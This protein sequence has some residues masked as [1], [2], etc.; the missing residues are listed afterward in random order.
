MNLKQSILATLAF[1]DIFDHPLRLEEIQ[2]NL[3]HITEKKELIKQYLKESGKVD[4]YDGFYFLFNKK[5]LISKRFHRQKSIDKAWSKIEGVQR[6]IAWLP[7]IEHISV[8]N[9]LALN[10]YDK[11][12]DMDLFIITKDKRLFTARFL[13]TLVFH[14]FGLRRHGKIIAGR[15]CLSFF[16]SKSSLD[17]GK[18]AQKPM[19][20]Y[21]AFWI[22][23]LIPIY[24][25]LDLIKTIY[26]KNMYWLKKYFTLPIQTNVSRKKPL[27]GK[28]RR[29]IQ[30][31]E[32]YLSGKFGDFI[33]EKLKKWQ[34]RRALIKKLKLNDSTGTII[35]PTMLKF[36]DV[37]RRKEIYSE[38]KR[39]LEK[40][41][42]E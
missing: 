5:N 2:E 37:D 22:K 18:I 8:C 30:I 21:L 12:S 28:S 15:F 13:I 29:F 3:L 1:Y 34:I 27:E 40:L 25:P 36:H 26:A 42:V 20:I 24:D 19:D 11:E 39:R 33:E 32:N 4:S 41:K 7:F 16:A 17:L 14:L 23:T 9:T 31:I 38:W 35:S 6:I 10:V